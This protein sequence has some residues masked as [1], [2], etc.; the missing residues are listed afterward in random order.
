[1]IQNELNKNAAKVGVLKPNQGLIYVTV[2][3]EDFMEDKN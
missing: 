2:K 3:V 1:M